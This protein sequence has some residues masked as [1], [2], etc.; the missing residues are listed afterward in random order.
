MNLPHHPIKF[1]YA[2]HKV[3]PFFSKRTVDPNSDLEGIESLSPIFQ[4]LS[5]SVEWSS[6]VESVYKDLPNLR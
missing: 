4:S 3:N 2:N 5:G 1:L 6:S